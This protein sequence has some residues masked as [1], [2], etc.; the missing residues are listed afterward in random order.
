MTQLPESLLS[1][2]R[3]YQHY[4]QQPH[5]PSM[6]L[7]EL[8][9]P[10]A[11]W[12]QLI[13]AMF[14]SLFYCSNDAERLMAYSEDGKE[15]IRLRRPEIREAKD[16]AFQHNGQR[17]SIPME[18][19]SREYN[20]FIDDFAAAGFPKSKAHL[21]T[22]FFTLT[23]RTA[24]DEVKAQVLDVV[25][26]H[27]GFQFSITNDE[28]RVSL[29]RKNG[30]G[31]PPLKCWSTLITLL[32]KLFKDCLLSYPAE[33][34]TRRDT[35]LFDRPFLTG[36][37]QALTITPHAVIAPLLSTSACQ[38]VRRKVASD[39][40]HLTAQGYP[41]KNDMQSYLAAL[42]T[43]RELQQVMGTSFRG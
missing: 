31:L 16:F 41:L 25:R 2:H 43:P 29:R 26:N 13:Q 7:A 35:H 39:I 19:Y 37:V 40:H 8:G 42:L 3:M 38:A 4:N 5:S 14:D 34:P 32:R 28:I 18:K 9:H 27:E 1:L 20:Q 6:R 36:N 10:L 21:G 17:H 33:P 15:Q 12:F 23:V 22:S 30:G 11:R 24:R